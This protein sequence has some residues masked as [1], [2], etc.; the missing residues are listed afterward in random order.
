MAGET[1]LRTL[2]RTLTPELNPGDYVFCTCAAGALPNGAEPLASFREREGLTLV[3][4]RLGLPYEYVAAWITLTV[5]SSLAAVGLTA[6]FAT[7]LAEAGISCNVMAG[8]FHD[9]LFV[10]RDEGR[11]ALA[12]LQ[13]L[14]AE[15]H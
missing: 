6:A 14:A 15:A 9:H 10:A 3:L 4:E 8:Y 1:S 11:R 2:L 5:H 7:T 13:R 12:V